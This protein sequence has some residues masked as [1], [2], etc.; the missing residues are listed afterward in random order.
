MKPQCSILLPSEALANG[1]PLGAREA[2]AVTQLGQHLEQ[3]LIKLAWTNLM[4]VAD[5]FDS[6]QRSLPFPVEYTDYFESRPPSPG[7]APP[8]ADFYI[9]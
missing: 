8:L 1:L 4:S 9:L 3:S 7:R 5:S 2:I 6:S